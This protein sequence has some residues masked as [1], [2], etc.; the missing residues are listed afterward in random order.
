M[1]NAYSYDAIR[2]CVKASDSRDYGVDL[3]VDREAL[4]MAAIDACALEPSPIGCPSTVKIQRKDC[5]FY[6]DYPTNLLV[7]ATTRFVSQRFRVSVPNRD[8]VVKSVIEMMADGSPFHVIRRD[9]RSFYENIPTVALREKLLFDTAIPR[10]VR[11]HLR[12]YFALAPDPERGLPRGIGLT[13]ILAELA[14][15]AFDQAVRS[16]PGVYR[17]FRYSDDIL[18]F[19]FGDLPAIETQIGKLLPQSMTF[20][21]AKCSTASFCG[22]AVADATDQFD[23]LGYSF[24]SPK[25]APKRGKPRPCSVSISEGKINKLKTRIILSMKKYDPSNPLLLLYRMRYLS[26]NY[27]VTRLPGYYELTGN[28]SRSGI[29]HNYKRCGI[30]AGPTHTPEERKELMALDWF[31]H[32]LLNSPKSNYGGI[33]ASAPPIVVSQLRRISFQ[34]GHSLRLQARVPSGIAGQVKS[35]WRDH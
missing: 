4:V 28:F 32:N 34:K 24:K 18:V 15:D 5:Y 20:N 8:Q 33:V 13:T 16:I 31:Y 23:Y 14:M 17:Y 1:R 30:H 2:R 7:R 10:E 6:P 29:Y 11:R 27:R 35:A 26:G 21:L 22:D 9:I 3:K 25:N 12:Y 19:C